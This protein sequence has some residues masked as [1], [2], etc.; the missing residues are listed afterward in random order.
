MQRLYAGILRVLGERP[1]TGF[2]I[3]P[4]LIATCAHVVGRQRAPGTVVAGA[5]WQRD[6]L[7]L[8]LLAIDGDIDLALLTCD[9]RRHC[10]LQPCR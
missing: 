2:A 4:N 7:D 1:G 8:R 9:D 6:V 3:A 10:P 5:P